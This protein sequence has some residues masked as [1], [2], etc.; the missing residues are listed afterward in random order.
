M[1]VGFGAGLATV[2]VPLF[3]SEI[4]PP[5]IK[6]SLGIMN[7][8][9]IVIGMLL[10]QS[11]SIPL[12]RY[13]QWRWVFAVSAGLAVLQILGSLAIS[14]PEVKREVRDA[15][16]EDQP[17]LEG[18]EDQVKEVMSIKDLFTSKDQVIRRGREW[19][20][21]ACTLADPSRDRHR[22]AAGTAAMRHLP[23]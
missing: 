10:G 21:L 16:G 8:L 20:A 14:A 2:S 4:A 23:R 7:Q 11:L 5:S 19:R 3:L 22:H 12:T 15:G 13:G 1:C 9:F 18:G 17:L 6:K